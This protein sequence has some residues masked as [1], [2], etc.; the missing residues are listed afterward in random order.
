MLRVTK[1]LFKIL[2]K[3]QKTNIIG[4]T[5]LMLIGAF[6][7]S[8]SASSMLP[9]V[10]GVM[11]SENWRESSIA[12]I[13]I[14]LVHTN[15][16]EEYISI[17]LLGMII[18]F[19]VKNIF[20]LFEY[21]AQYDFIGRSRMQLQNALMKKYMSMQY[22]FFLS[23]ST[24]EIMRVVLTDST[25]TFMLLTNVMS[26]YTELFVAVILAVTI[27]IMSPL[28]ALGII[29]IL[30]IEVL[31]I[32]LLI[33]PYMR[34][35]GI[36]YREEAAIANKWIMESVTGIKSIKV[37]NSS[38]F[39][40]TNYCKHAERMINVEKKNNV[41]NVMPRLI[42]EA[43]TITGVFCMM[44]LLVKTGVSVQELVPQLSVIVIA[45]LRLLPSVNR[46]SMYLNS[47]SFME[48][49]LDN[50]IDILSKKIN[51]TD[52]M[53]N[54]DR[55]VAV[56]FDDGLKF[57]NV[58]FSYAD[59]PRKVLNNANIYIKPGESIGII[60]ASGAGKT[61]VMDLMLGLLVPSDGQVMIDDCNINECRKSWLEKIAYIPQNI[62]LS[63]STI[64]ENVAFGVKK[65]DIDDK[66]VWNA[67]KKAQLYDYVKKLPKGID[68]SVGEAGVK[69]SGGQRQRIGIARALYNKP[70]VL[71]FDEA[72][73]A[74]DNDTE[75]AIMQSINDLKHE[76]TLIIIAHRISTLKDC[77]VIYKVENGKIT[78][79][80]KQ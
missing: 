24:A 26:I 30:I 18:L 60:G 12:K 35:Y 63:N 1:K 62:F 68:T 67:I 39:Y 38:S 32:F 58:S 28:L 8:L 80:K 13:L 49:S 65:E 25:Q 20:L 11:N 47:V 9:L 14:R 15:S 10:E 79:C 19:F 57:E 50:V 61:T 52:E 37:T 73:S 2:T 77:D 21:Y 75:E 56:L 59:N 34:K 7:E 4:L 33:K 54:N 70:D 27:I 72:T 45:A 42:I 5:L 31:I 55:T 74:L 17:L 22:S 46:I 36:V 43:F 3:K 78:A 29:V 64:K 6:M 40:L 71:F 41:F 48:G 16:Q 23:K 66:Q 53:Q 51:D 44:L 76:K 69:L